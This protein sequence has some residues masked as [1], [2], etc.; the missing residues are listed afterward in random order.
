MSNKSY[1]LSDQEHQY[2]MQNTVREHPLMTEL[3]LE[4]M[5]LPM[6]RMQIAPEQAQ[7]MQLLLAMLGARRAIEVGVFTGYSALAIAM[8]LPEDGHLVACDISEEYTAIAQPYWQRA[9]MNSK[10]DLR[11][12]PASETL[13]ELLAGG[14]AE[15]YDFAF[16]DADKESYSSY[17]EQCLALLRPGGV[18]AIDNA[19]WDGRV[20]DVYQVD[21]E[22]SAI[23]EVNKLIGSD[24]R[25]ECSLVPIGDGLL[26]ARKL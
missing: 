21:E 23:R 7:F 25:V 4:T 9:G 1:G 11:L 20:A 2:L 3:R 19:L 15:D 5:A 10:I 12:A 16:I 24:T 17:Y 22:T 13:D 18:I 26:L 6:A 8:A 14:G